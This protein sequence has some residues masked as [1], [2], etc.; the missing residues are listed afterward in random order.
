MTKKRKRHSAEFKARVALEAV[1]GLKT[2][3]E[4]ARDYQVHPTQISQWKRHLLDQLPDVFRHGGSCRAG[5]DG[6]AV[7]R[8]RP[9]EDGA[10][11]GKKKCC[12]AS[13]RVSAW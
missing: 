2:S 11:L 8:D 10:R 7:R 1:K 13:R 12:Q 5:A 9:V 6:T 3:S 4:L